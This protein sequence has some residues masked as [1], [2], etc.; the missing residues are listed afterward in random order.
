MS[1]RLRILLLTGLASALVFLFILIGF[2]Y[3]KLAAY[4]S[5]QLEAQTGTQVSIQDIRPYLHVLGPG[6]QASGIHTVVDSYEIEIDHTS[7]RP[8]WS[9]SWL[10]A[11]P[12]LQT[13]IETSAGDIEGTVT[14]GKKMGFDGFVELR[15]VGALPLERWWPGFDLEGEGRIEIDARLDADGPDGTIE[16]DVVQGSIGLP[17]LPVAIPFDEIRGRLTMGGDHW[18]LVE[19]FSLSGPVI[20]AEVSGQVARGPSLE[21]APV[22]IDIQVSAEPSLHPALASAG[23][24]MGGD[25]SALIQVTGTA[26]NLRLR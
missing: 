22:S 16:F 20:D 9:L 8:A 15:D 24:L 25:G 4:V 5:A 21:Q 14:L 10:R 6:I 18:T 13:H 3:G 17:D 19:E 2:P 12:A 1:G 23:I 26:S 11:D 7:L